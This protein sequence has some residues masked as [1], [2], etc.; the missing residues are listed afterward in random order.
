MPS[1][2]DQRAAA[3]ARAAAV[4]AW[5]RP[6]TGPATPDAQASGPGSGQDTGPP[7]EVIPLPIFDPFAEAGKRW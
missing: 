4:P 5:P 6:D 1:K 7:A 2:K 3:R